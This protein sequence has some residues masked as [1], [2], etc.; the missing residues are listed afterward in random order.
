MWPGRIAGAS[1][2]VAARIG[3]SFFMVFKAI[4]L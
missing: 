2:N 4:L 3:A 1:I